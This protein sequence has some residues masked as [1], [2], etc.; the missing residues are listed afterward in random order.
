MKSK[1]EILNRLRQTGERITPPREAVIEALCALG[2]HQTT[3]SI[4]QY[5]HENGI[6]LREATVYR[7][8]Q[9]LKDQAVVSQTDLGQPEIIYELLSAP[10]HH[11]L[12][13]LQCGQIHDLDDAAL[14]ELRQ[15]LRDRYQFEPRIDHMAIFGTCEKCRSRLK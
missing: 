8:L 9:W 1:E 12:I 11:H 7:V 10:L 13:C 2:N 14:K 3:Q 4:Q 15:Q 5:L 6:E